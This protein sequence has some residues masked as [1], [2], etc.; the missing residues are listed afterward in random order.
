MKKLL[1]AATLLLSG[2]QFATAQTADE[3]VAKHITAIGG[4][5]NWKKLNTLQMEITM[6]AQGAEIGM[7]RTHIHNKAMRMDISVMGMSGY[8]ILTTK[9]GWNYMPFQ[10]QTKAE[11]MTADDVKTSQ[12]ELNIM[13]E[14]IT[15]KD[16]GKK[17]EYLGTD[18]LEGTEC[19]KLKMTDKDGQETT[20]YLDK[21]NYYTLKQVQKMKA[22]GKETEVVMT[23][24]NYKM[25]PE[26]IL[27]AHSLGGDWG[28]MEISKILVNSVI[29]ENLFKP[30]N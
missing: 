9:E 19:F 29:D 2:F 1:F 4:A 11:P 14:F 6:K 16:K 23:F 3:I 5:D 25:L 13:D 8:S 30:A 10:G 28:D 26:G 21:S 20:Y 18:D 15:Y 12:D 22:N 24:S 17:I 27:Y 7:K